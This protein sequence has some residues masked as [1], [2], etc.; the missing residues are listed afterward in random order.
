MMITLGGTLRSLIPTSENRLILTSENIAAIQSGIGITA[1]KI[2]KKNIRPK[3]P[4]P[5]RNG[6][7]IDILNLHLLF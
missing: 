7:G 3:I 5:I 1:E 2:M 4:R 6:A